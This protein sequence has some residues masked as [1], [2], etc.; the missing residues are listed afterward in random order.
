[1][2]T[3]ELCGGKVA[4]LRGKDL[5]EQQRGAYETHLRGHGKSDL[6][7]APPDQHGHCVEPTTA[8]RMAKH[9]LIEEACAEDSESEFVKRW[10]KA[11][12][13]WEAGSSV[14]DIAAVYGV[15]EK[16][17]R[18][19]VKKWRLKLGWFMPRNPKD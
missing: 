17:M 12:V 3:C 19:R 6:Y 2:I 4:T 10:D 5:P 18:A 8:A 1:M 7:G 13:M 16:G 11:R 15:S 14:G 9:V